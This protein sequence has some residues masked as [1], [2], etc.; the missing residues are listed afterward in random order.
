MSV[1]VGHWNCSQIQ[2]DDLT[3]VG[4][5]HAKDGLVGRAMFHGIINDLAVASEIFG[6]EQRLAMPPAVNAR[7]PADLPKILRSGN[8]VFMGI[9]RPRRHPAGGHR[10][11]EMTTCLRDGLLRFPALG[12]VD[13]GA[14]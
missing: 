7:H 1:A 8:N 5:D 10:E 6:M 12:D 2:P 3:I 11:V 13:A 9:P 14:D 4:P